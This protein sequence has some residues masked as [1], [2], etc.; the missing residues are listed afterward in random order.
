MVH[1]FLDSYSDKVLLKKEKGRE[2][3]LKSSDFTIVKATAS[4]YKDSVLMI[5]KIKHSDIS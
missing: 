5:I 2:K 1:V 3:S 4:L